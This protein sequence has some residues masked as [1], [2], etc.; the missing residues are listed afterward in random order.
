MN[1]EF[2]I[3]PVGPKELVKYADKGETLYGYFDEVKSVIY[4]DNTL[5][6]HIYDRILMHELTHA[7]LSI[8]GI[9]NLLTS[10]LEES[11]CDAME[12][13]ITLLQ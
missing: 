6:Q 3:N 13:F 9:C 4:I 5:E 12:N 10:K 8:T 1:K 7:I 11:I 2:L